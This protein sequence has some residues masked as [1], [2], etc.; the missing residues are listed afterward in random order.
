MTQTTIPLEFE[1]YLQAKISAGQPTDLNEVIFA[2]LPNV[3]INQP[4]DRNL[5]LPDE[6]YWVHQKSVDQ[7]GKT[8]DNAVVYSAILPAQT[9]TFTFN[10]I[11]LHDKNVANSCGL[12]IIKEDEKKEYGTASNKS[13]I[14]QY[15]GAALMGAITVDAETWQIDYSARVNGI[16][17]DHR[18]ACLDSYGHTAFI[19]GFDVI[20][21][22]GLN[23]YKITPGLAYVGGLRGS[24]NIEYIHTINEKPNTLYL[25][26]HREG[27]ALSKWDNTLIIRE[28]EIE[29]TDYIDTNGSPHYVAKLATINADYSVSDLRVEQTGKLE[30]ADNFASN[31]DIDNASSESKHINLPQF[32]RGIAKELKAVFP[33]GAPLPWPTEIAPTGFALMKGQAFN[34]TAYPELALAYPDGIIP[35]MRGLAIVGAKEGET[36]L[37]YEADT[38]KSH[39]HAA[40]LSAADLGSKQTNSSTHDHE[41]A[42]IPHSGEPLGSS[43]DIT[44]SS[45]SGG[46]S[47]KRT[48]SSSHAHSV[49]IGLHSHALSIGAYGGEENTIK[50][51]KFNWIVRLA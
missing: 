13:L 20:Q 47:A 46:Y 25:D 2:Y 35:D 12:A 42:N 48:S 24:L 31:D 28:S 4:I 5:G 18:L 8:G 34:T 9:Q 44:S 3:D 50:N 32:W 38:V 30:R 39:A 43:I 21:I 29:L 10:A 40:S 7:V 1:A 16:D 33:A 11:Y 14:Q 49:E 17:E 41:V 51:R 23:Q 37:A 15:S 19:E 36:V 6:T 45:Q 27:T 26:I 22:T